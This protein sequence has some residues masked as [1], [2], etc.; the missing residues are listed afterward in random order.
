MAVYAVGD[1]Q[2]CLKPLKTL[3][4]KLHFSPQ[5]DRLWIA[6]DMVNRGPHS[7]ETLRFIYHIRHA[8]V[9]VLGNHD[10]HL[11]AL[12]TGCRRPNPADT[13][14]PILDAPDRDRLLDWLR[15]Q[16]LLHHDKALGYTMVHA[17]IPPQWSIAQSC[18]YAAEVAAVLT[19]DHCTTF[20]QHMYGNHP[21]KWDE[22]LTSYDRWRVITNYFTRMRFCT[23][24]GQLELTAKGTINHG[25]QGYLP[26]FQ[27][28][29]RKAHNDNIIFGHWAAL[30]GSVC[31]KNLFA[32]DSGCVWGKALTAMRL[33]DKTMVSV[34]CSPATTY[35]DKHRL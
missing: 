29:D 5:T 21:S 11:L 33:D 20:L 32:L 22:S 19:G 15:R 18:D 25:P 24:D 10:L 7:L 1:I 3:L 8:V 28:A 27:Q 9:A 14:Q 16:P 2:G 26:W 30:E 12:A 23:A 13:L 4:N 31:E 6:G 34:P 35:L 17:G